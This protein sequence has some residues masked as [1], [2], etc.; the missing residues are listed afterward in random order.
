[1]ET[2]SDAM[3]H[4]VRSLIAVLA[5]VAAPA[6]AHHSIAAEFDASAL[7]VLDG[8]V[9]KVE[10]M[11]PH[12]YIWVDVADERGHVTNWM[13]ESAAPNYLQRLAWSKQ[14]LKPGDR[15]IIR[16]FMAKGQKGVAKT[17]TVT[18]PDGRSITTGHAVDSATERKSRD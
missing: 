16:A 13:V 3:A 9:T 14:S 10:W 17:D 2:V 8:K 4:M 7:V 18:L 6:W 15:V 5:L 11:N 12:V 1:M